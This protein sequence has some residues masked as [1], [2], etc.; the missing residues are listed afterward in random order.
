M[1]TPLSGDSIRDRLDDAIPQAIRE[2]DEPAVEAGQAALGAI[3]S[4]AGSAQRELA[5]AEILAIVLAEAVTREDQA[6]EK[7]AA[8]DTEEADRLFAQAAYLREFTA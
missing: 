5:E 8:G 1:A 4:A 6:R 7:R 3:E 2:G